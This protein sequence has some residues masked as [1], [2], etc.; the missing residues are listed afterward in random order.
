[1]RH[2]LE[3]PSGIPQLA[4]SQH[5]ASSL[6]VRLHRSGLAGHGPECSPGQHGGPALT[7]IVNRPEGDGEPPD[8]HPVGCLLGAVP[9]A[10][11]GTCH[12]GQAEQVFLQAPVTIHHDPAVLEED[13]SVSG[14][15]LEEPDSG[16]L[17]G[18]DLI[19]SLEFPLG[20]LDDLAH[21]HDAD[22]MGDV[23]D[24]RQIVGD[25]EIGQIELLLQV[26]HQVQHDARAA[27][28]IYGEHD[29]LAADV[30]D[31]IDAMFRTWRDTLDPAADGPGKFA[32]EEI[33]REASARGVPVYLFY[34]VNES[35]R[36]CGVALMASPVDPQA[37]LP[38]WLPVRFCFVLWVL[39]M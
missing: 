5:L 12:P 7:D 18:I 3:I 35:R 25:E 31:L 20:H 26:L 34:S 1:M 8:I 2:S 39:C 27:Q 10:D 4:A 15:E 17:L 32:A 6:N 11:Q 22:S 9:G 23:L 16:H 14:Q 29:S 24:H 37:S 13:E 38:D 36:F 28:E 30:E 33:R 19:N 21:I